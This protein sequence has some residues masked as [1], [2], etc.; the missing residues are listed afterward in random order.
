[1][2]ATTPTIADAVAAARALAPALRARAEQV[3]E[4]RRMPP[5]TLADFRAAGFYRM[6]VPVEHGGWG[7][8]VEAAVRVSFE[9]AQ[10]CAS[11]G[12]IAAQIGID[13][14]MVT[15]FPKRAQGEFWADGPDVGAASANALLGSEL[16]STAG[17]YAI[18]NGRWKFA[19]GV[20]QAQ[21][22]I[23]TQPARGGAPMMLVPRGD[24]A[25]DDDW[26]TVG[27]RGTGSGSVVIE[28]AEVPSYRTAPLGSVPNHAMSIWVLG[29]VAWGAALGASRDF[30]RIVATRRSAKDLSRPGERDAVQVAIARSTVEL[31]C[32]EMLFERD[33]ALFREAAR[34]GRDLA[35]HEALRVSRDC[36]Y[37]CELAYRGTQTLFDE[38]GSSV[39]YESNPVQRALRDIMAATRHGRVSWALNGKNYGMWLLGSWADMT[40]NG[41]DDRNAAFPADAVNLGGTSDDR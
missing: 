25:I 9:L 26:F 21:W 1:M 15:A 19:S 3:A 37:V 2:P 33:V 30:G 5:E 41:C 24:F 38:F 36:A 28:S 12:W 16:T 14:L 11:S 20:N 10:A 39:I 6:C 35:R 32:C 29:A 13:A 22:L 40:R 4:L 8:D 27:L 31:E 7:L 18:R 23:L 17:G 34:E